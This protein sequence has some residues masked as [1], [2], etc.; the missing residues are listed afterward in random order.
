[1]AALILALKR[2]VQRHRFA[3]HHKQQKL[4]GT[5]QI[6]QVHHQSV[7]HL[8]QGLHRAVELTGAHAQA[9]AVDRRVTAAVD[10]AAALGVILSQSP[11]RQTPGYMSK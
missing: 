4:A 1:M 8:G 2:S 10:D 5:A 7:Q 9:V 11:W 3:Q 6:L